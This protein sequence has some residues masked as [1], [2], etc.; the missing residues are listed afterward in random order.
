MDTEKTA[1]HASLD[2]VVGTHVHILMWTRKITQ[3]ALGRQ[4]GIDQSAL[5]KKLRGERG[6]SLDEVER[7]ARV[8]GVPMLSLFD[9]NWYTPRDLNPEPTD[10]GIDN[11]TPI[12][13][14]PSMRWPLTGGSAA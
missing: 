8:L 4:L 3:S 1:E 13:S 7:A 5:S 14:A 10:S 11:V 9:R 2:Q 6:W 12:D